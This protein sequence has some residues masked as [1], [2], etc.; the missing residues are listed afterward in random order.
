MRRLGELM[1][2]QKETVGMAPPAARGKN[3]PSL[4]PTLK[5]VGINKDMAKEARHQAAKPAEKFEFM[6]M[7][8][9]GIKGT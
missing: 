1:K 9:L 6:Y 3:P 7:R 2:L 5:E 4:K 8:D